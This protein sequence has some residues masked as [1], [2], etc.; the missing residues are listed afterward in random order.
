MTRLKK[1]HSIQF[2]KNL[3]GW[4]NLI[5]SCCTKIVQQLFILHEYYLKNTQNTSSTLTQL[6]RHK[7][8][9]YKCILQHTTRV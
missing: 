1:I 4:L 6:T 2:E 3:C 7:L 9:Q 5:L 8:Q